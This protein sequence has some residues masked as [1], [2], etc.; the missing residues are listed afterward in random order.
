MILVSWIVKIVQSKS[1]LHP[2]M[3]NKGPMQYNTIVLE[4]YVWYLIMHFMGV[5]TRV[6][7]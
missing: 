7:N 2:K 5:S 1:K 4:I 6:H 3:R